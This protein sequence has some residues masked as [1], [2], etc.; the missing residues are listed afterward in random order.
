MISS[1]P[2]KDVCLESRGVSQ[3]DEHGALLTFDPCRKPVADL[4]CG[5]LICQ[6]VKGR[7]QHVVRICLQSGCKPDSV[8]VSQLKSAQSRQA[9]QSIARYLRSPTQIS[10]Q[11]QLPLLLTLATEL[12]FLTP[13]CWCQSKESLSTARKTRRTYG[14][15]AAWRDRPIFSTWRRQ[16]S[17]TGSDT[18]TLERSQVGPFRILDSTQCHE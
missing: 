16:I 4:H 18:R 7:I 6:R 5:R 15:A 3:G 8:T 14:V 12:I 1:Y 11:P 10:C 13:I 17:R 9:P 2:D